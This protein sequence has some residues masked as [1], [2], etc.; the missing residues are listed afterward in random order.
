M[1]VDV[2]DM[3]LFVAVVREGSFTAAA[4]VLGV[5][6]QQVSARVG[7]LEAALG[8]RLLE[9]TTRSVRPT[10]AGQR[11]HARCVE[12]EARVAE[13]NEE[14]RRLQAEPV[15]LLRVSA[16]TLF[17][18]RFLGPVV[19][20][21]R[22]RHPGLRIELALADRRVDLLEEGFDVAIRIGELGDSSLS[23][24]RLGLARAAFVASPAFLVGREQATVSTVGAW[25]WVGMRPVETWRCGER[26]LRIT[27]ALVVP[28]LEVVCDAVVAG[29]GMARLPLLVCG[30]ALA[31]GRLVEVL[32]GDGAPDIPVH[33]VYPSRQYLPARVR[34]FVDALVARAPLLDG[35]AG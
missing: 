14:A 15:G 1:R 25:P 19:A 7:R 29:A 18:R 16:P 30:E 13:A 22:S 2:A 3:F 23:A 8:V 4:R 12:L 10:D 26:E 34:L 9:R 17:A 32:R 31:A 24:R 28:D 20:A 35:H 6:K 11:Y 27:P 5:S 21:F 33:V